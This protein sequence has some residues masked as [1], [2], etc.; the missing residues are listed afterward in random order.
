MEDPVGV[1]QRKTK[2]DYDKLTNLLIFYVLYYGIIYFSPCRGFISE[3]NG[4]ISNVNL[5]AWT[6]LSIA[7]L[8]VKFSMN[9]D[10]TGIS[11]D[12]LCTIMSWALAKKLHLKQPASKTDRGKKSTNINNATC[13]K[14]T[15]TFIGGLIFPPIS[16]T[17]KYFSFTQK[18]RASRVA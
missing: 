14:N 15:S 9:C 4:C 7:L 6:V 16:F 8:T 5:S 18:C 11:V 10:P 17:Y 12:G 1:L 13:T 3:I 2:K